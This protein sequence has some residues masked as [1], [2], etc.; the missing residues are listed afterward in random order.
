MAAPSESK[1]MNGR[2][3]R[4][5]QH[6]LRRLFEGRLC[7]ADAARLFEHLASCPSCARLHE[8][9][10]RAERAL[11]PR[12]GPLDPLPESI[13]RVEARLRAGEGLG[14]E[15]WL[16]REEAP[17]HGPLDGSPQELF[18]FAGRLRGLFGLARFLRGPSGLARVLRGPSGLARRDPSGTARGAIG[19]LAGLASVLSLFVFLP[20]TEEPAEVGYQARGP[21]PKLLLGLR[22]LALSAEDAGASPAVREV[23]SDPRVQPGE[24]IVL[25][26]TAPSEAARVRVT[27]VAS[28]GRSIPMV[29]Q[30]LEGGPDQRVGAP[31]VVPSDW[32]GQAF[33]LRAQFE[34]DRGRPLGR[35]SRAILIREP[36][37]R[38][39][40]GRPPIC[41]ARGTTGRV[42]CAGSHSPRGA[43]PP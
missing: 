33:E 27:A 23:A 37:A 3:H 7:G 4:R 25:L 5:A 8:R 10:A 42:W 2:A 30:D 15:R 32:L 19:L 21:G 40:L 6:H 17:D 24:Q 11:H 22:V 28:S 29:E 38:L 34:T 43:V 16:G 35:R 39:P 1:H 36:S 14:V 18:G 13:E 20:P 31:F 12:L 9:Y 41:R 26:V